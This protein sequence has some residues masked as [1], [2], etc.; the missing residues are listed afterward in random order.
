MQHRID[1]RKLGRDSGAR[2]SLLKNLVTSLFE[3][4]KIV[5]TEAKAKEVRGIAEKLITKA[6]KNTLHV[7][8]QVASVVNQKRVVKRL[9][10]EILTKLE[11]SNNGGYTRIVKIGNRKGDN[12]PLVLL[13]IVDPSDKEQKH[14]A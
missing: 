9:F 10:D 6:K 1:G 8:R 14:Q 12:A 2:R 13:E 5:T 4:D 11:N 3:H 7:R